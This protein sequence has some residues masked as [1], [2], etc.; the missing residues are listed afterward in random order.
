MPAKFD[1]CAEQGGKIRTVD[2]SKTK[3]ARV[4]VLPGN[5]TG[6]RGGKTVMGE[7]R[8]RKAPKK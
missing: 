4:C 6:P 5:Q 3:F 8:E 7:V 1:K 2:V